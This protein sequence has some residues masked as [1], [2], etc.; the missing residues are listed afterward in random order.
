[1]LNDEDFYNSA[2]RLMLA[3]LEAEKDGR[4]TEEDAIALDDLLATLITKVLRKDK[5][6]HILH[7]N[8]IRLLKKTRGYLMENAGRDEGIPCMEEAAEILQAYILVLSHIEQDRTHDRKIRKLLEDF[9]KLD[10][11]KYEYDD[12]NDNKLGDDLL[13]M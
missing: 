1:M 10:Y 8:E 9:D 6:M 3:S 2:K 5:E 7:E 11:Q 4:M 12:D 13:G